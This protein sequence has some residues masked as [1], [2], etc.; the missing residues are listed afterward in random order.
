M[1]ETEF[2]FKHLNFENLNIVSNIRTSS[3]EFQFR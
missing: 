2:R 3:F 1:T